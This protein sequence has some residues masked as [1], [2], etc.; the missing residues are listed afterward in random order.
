MAFLF[1]A[2]LCIPALEDYSVFSNPFPFPPATSTNEQETVIKNIAMLTII[3]LP[4]IVYAVFL[5]RG[6]LR[7]AKKII[8]SVFPFSWK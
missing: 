3:I 4:I 2:K 5:E 7:N 1:S 6:R 8:H